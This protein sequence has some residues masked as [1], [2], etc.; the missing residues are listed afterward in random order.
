[1]AGLAMMTLPSKRHLVA[2]MCT[3]EYDDVLKLANEVLKAGQPVY[4]ITQELYSQYG[5][6]EI[7]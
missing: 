1:M 3:H 6:L 7:T 4:D 5:L 2:L